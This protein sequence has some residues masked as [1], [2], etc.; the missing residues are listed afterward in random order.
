MKKRTSKKMLPFGICIMLVLTLPIVTSISQE[1]Y[2]TSLSNNQNTELKILFFGSLQLFL[3]P[4]VGYGIENRGGE[5]AY[6]V[7]ATFT[8]EGGLSDSIYF[9]ET[10]DYTEIL[11]GY[12]SGRSWI[13]AIDG[14]GLVTI[15]VNVGASNAEDIEKTANGFQIGFRTF[16]FG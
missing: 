15:T 1:T 6:N 9:T 4:G 5:S 11:P 14:F 2:T 8:L 12:T 16:I 13:R 10:R 3:L 7:T